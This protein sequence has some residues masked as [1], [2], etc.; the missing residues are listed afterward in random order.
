M[1]VTSSVEAYLARPPVRQ[2]PVQHNKSKALPAALGFRNG[3]M[4]VH[5]SRTMMFG[6][7]ALVLETV[8]G[9]VRPDAY[10][11][12]IVEENVLGKPTQT[13]RQRT[14]KRLE[15]LYCLGPNCALFRLMRHF[16]AADQ[17]SRPMLAFLAAAARD[18]LLRETT[19]FVQAIA[20]GEPVTPDEI[21]KHLDQKYPNRFRPTTLHSTAQNLA[22]SWTQAGYLTGKVKKSRSIP[23][24]T[25]VTAAFAF[26]LGYL[27]GLR[28]RLLLGCVW[29][30]LLDRSPSDLSH[31]ATEASKQGWLVYK[32]A[33]AI[34]EITF[35]GLLTASEE[36]ASHESN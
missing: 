1:N 15:E 12:A 14:A 4:S 31:L 19:P 33:G 11:A 10:I 8:P 25:P 26:V 24:V 6:E 27:C 30:R 36:E 34:V 9:N 32:H 18:P 21:A 22:S 23:T 16:W 28:G 3:S 7:L 2:N 17:A 20:V 35:P 5:T 13:T 29:T